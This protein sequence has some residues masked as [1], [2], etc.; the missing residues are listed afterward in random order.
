VA[1]VDWHAA[2]DA[3]GRIVIAAGFGVGEAA[4]I[5]TSMCW[6]VTALAFAAAGRRIGSTAVN[7][8]RL[9]MAAAILG[10]VHW[11]V[12]G[13]P[14]PAMDATSLAWLAL[15]GVVGLA[16]GDQLLFTALVDVGPRLSTLLMTLAPPVTAVAAWPILDEP[17]GMVAMAG[18][19]VTMAGIGWV[20][21][22][23]S[24]EADPAEAARH[25]SRGRHRLRGLLFATGAAF[26]QAAGLVLSK[27]GMGHTRLAEDALLD[28]WPATFVRM[29]FGAASMVILATMIRLV[30]G[31]RRAEAAIEVSPEQE[32]LPVDPVDA[33]GPRVWPAS[34]GL[35]TIGAIFGPVLGVWL[36]LVSVDRAPAGV[37]ATLTSLSP[38]FILPAVAWLERERI[39]WRAVAGAVVA[40]TGVAV[41]TAFDGNGPPAD[42][43]TDPPPPAAISETMDER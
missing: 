3:T 11:I 5:A 38:V 9:F 14:W 10:A 29:T 30:I 40:V 33:D 1:P 26:C 25:P 28:P 20:V 8:I 41:L 17:L 23:R 16:I 22:E 24:P 13:A 31:W 39:T 12:F 7:L 36:S 4:G 35:V 43:A 2:G 32:R 21:M 18:I 42:G 37:A 34:L 6:V 19:I 27:L 15:S